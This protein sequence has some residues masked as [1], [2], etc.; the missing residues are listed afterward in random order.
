MQYLKIDV[1]FFAL[2]GKG[3]HLWPNSFSAAPKEEKYN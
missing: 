1:T 3:L 2:S